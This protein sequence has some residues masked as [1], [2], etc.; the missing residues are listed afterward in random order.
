MADEQGG[1]YSHGMDI[2]RVRD[3]AARLTQAQREL[4]G[5]RNAADD[6][7]RQLGQHW[8]GEDGAAFTRRW[9]HLKH[10]LDTQVGEVGS[11]VRSLRTQVQEQEKAS[12]KGTGNGGGDDGP[13]GPGGPKAPDGLGHNN[14]RGP[15]TD[16]PGIEGQTT[17]GRVEE[18]TDTSPRHRDSSEN[19]RTDTDTR[20]RNEDGEQWERGRRWETTWT[21][22]DADGDGTPDAAEDNDGDGTP[23]SEEGQHR[24][25]S[26]RP[27]T[28]VKGILWEDEKELWDAE[29][30]GHTFGDENGNHLTV[31]ALSSEGK[32][33]GEASIGKDGLA[34]AGTATAAGYLVH[35]GGQYSTSFGTQAKGEAYVGGEANANAGVSLGMDGVKASAGG[36]VFVGGKAEG[37]VSQDL[38]PVDV[39]VGG[40]ISYGLGAHAEG[41]VAFSTDEVG[42]SLDIGAT[43]GVGGGLSVDVGID[44]TFWN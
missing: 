17:P 26:R 40:E 31:E 11:L 3:L 41:D 28:E 44:P 21:Q 4:K 1:R 20:Y 23:D 38:G 14:N 33:E 2:E 8:A 24:D 22:T 43:L 37:Q 42:V 19:T 29:Y 34:L 7:A 39:G 12:G 18:T 13:G 25:D 30:A 32:L 27:P 36:E 15:D 6:A 35:A 9:P 10:V 5:A 16:G